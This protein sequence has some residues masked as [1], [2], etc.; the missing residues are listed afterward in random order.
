MRGTI[1]NFFAKK[2]EKKKAYEDMNEAERKVYDENRKKMEEKRK[3]KEE[4]ALKNPLGTT[5]A[6][7]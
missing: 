5:N 7:A 3:K 6:T 1:V 4:E 2:Q